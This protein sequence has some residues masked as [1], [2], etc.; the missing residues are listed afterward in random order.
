MLGP[1]VSSLGGEEK[2]LR[3]FDFPLF[4]IDLESR[5]SKAGFTQRRSVRRGWRERHWPLLCDLC[6]SA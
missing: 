2:Q 4:A 3:V 1:H 5:N 6:A